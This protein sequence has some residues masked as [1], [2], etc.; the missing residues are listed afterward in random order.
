MKRFALILIGCLFAVLTAKADSLWIE[1]DG[2]GQVGKAQLVKVIFG[3]Y[4]E[5][6]LQNVNTDDSKE[7][8]DFTCW[9]ISPSGKQIALDFSPK[10]TSYEATFTP[11]EKGIYVLLLE[12]KQRR[13]ED[14]SKST[15]KIG[16][17][18][19]N[20]YSR[21]TIKIGDSDAMAKD[22]VTDLSIVRFPDTQTGADVTLQA[23][24]HGKPVPNAVLFLRNPGMPEQKFTT[25]ENGKV[26]FHSAKPGRYF[27][28]V[29]LK[30]ETPGTYRGIHYDV[31]REKSCMTMVLD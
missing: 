16:I 6:R 15:S 30:F 24:L 25:D 17:A 13:V 11:T 7:A 5:Y 3:S 14:W 21:T 1:V 28:L 8:K 12:N 23:L 22:A 4:N 10:T 2:T 19:Q 18:K 26:S 31:F 27:A 20:Y 9:A 29:T